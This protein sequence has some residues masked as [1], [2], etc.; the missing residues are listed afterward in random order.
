MR[1]IRGTGR[2]YK[3]PKRKIKRLE[4]KDPSLLQEQPTP[5][6]VHVVWVILIAA[7]LY[8]P[9]VRSPEMTSSRLLINYWWFYVPAALVIMSIVFW[10]RR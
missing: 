3:P 2:T 9:F 8:F 7:S 4:F 5:I 10:R 6:W 1:S